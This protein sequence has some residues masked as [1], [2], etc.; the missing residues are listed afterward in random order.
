MSAADDCLAGLPRVTGKVSDSFSPCGLREPE[1]ITLT[2][3]PLRGSHNVLLEFESHV[4]H[5]QTILTGTYFVG[6]WRR[7]K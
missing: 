7:R 6:A 2:P 4:N 5:N 1:N 3:D